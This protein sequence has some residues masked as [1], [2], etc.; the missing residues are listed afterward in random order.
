[1]LLCEWT[2]E[3]TSE[4]RNRF[5]LQFFGPFGLF[6]CVHVRFQLKKIPAYTQTYS[7][8]WF[9]TN[10]YIFTHICANTQRHTNTHRKRARERGKANNCTQ[11]S[12]TAWVQDSHVCL[13]LLELHF[14]HLSHTTLTHISSESL[15]S[16]HTIVIGDDFARK[17]NVIDPNRAST[18]L[19]QQQVSNAGLFSNTHSHTHMHVVIQAVYLPSM[20]FCIWN[21]P[22]FRRFEEIKMKLPNKQRRNTFVLEFQ[23]H[24][25]AAYINHHLHFFDFLHFFFSWRNKKKLSG[26]AFPICI[27]MS[28]TNYIVVYRLI[29]KHTTKLRHKLSHSLVLRYFGHISTAQQAEYAYWMICIKLFIT[30]SEKRASATAKIGKKSKISMSNICLISTLNQPLLGVALCIPFHS[31]CFCCF[32]LVSSA[33]YNMYLFNSLLLPFNQ[34]LFFVCC[35]FAKR[36]KNTSSSFSCRM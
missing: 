17:K 11:S 27:F 24:F 31:I 23:P 21:R 1:M 34:L 20:T 33:F 26:M 18:P 10:G 35:R 28:Y 29:N 5:E 12:T 22:I 9:N 30:T 4:L 2:N 36:K 32:P 3:R 8:W 25:R 13:A 19:N 15:E 16:Y 6:I 14:I 7:P